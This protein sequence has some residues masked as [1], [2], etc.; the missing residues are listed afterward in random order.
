MKMENAIS[1]SMEISELFRDFEK[2][3]EL[4]LENLKKGLN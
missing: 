3:R 2:A 4:N 1:D